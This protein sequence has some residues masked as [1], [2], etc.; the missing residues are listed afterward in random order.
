MGGKWGWEW[1]RRRDH[2]EEVV[3]K[4]LFLFFS[5]SISLTFHPSSFF[6]LSSL[7]I[8]WLSLSLSPPSLSPSLSPFLSFPTLLHSH[9]L[10][11]VL[12]DFP[13]N[14]FPPSSFFGGH[15]MCS[16]LSVILSSPNN[17]TLIKWLFALF[18]ENFW[19]SFF[20]FSIGYTY[21]IILIS[22]FNVGE[23]RRSLGF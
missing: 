15:Q 18:G 16:A 22:T 19:I 12:E 6:F 14:Y 13:M 20:F 5:P 1:R 4:G 10:Y 11:F 7:I 2:E 3:G 9:C 8:W 21:L 17:N 23:V